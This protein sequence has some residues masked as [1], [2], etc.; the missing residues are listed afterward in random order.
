TDH[1]ES[2]TE[3]ILSTLKKIE[4]ASSAAIELMR[5]C[6]FLAPHAIPE[7]ILTEG[8]AELGSALQSVATNPVELDKGIAELRKFSLVRRSPDAKM[9]SLH[10]L[11]QATVEDSMSE[12]SRHVQASRVV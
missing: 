7:E 5:F 2:V 3:T 1:Q 6:A 10:T 12:D 9:L 11:V 4:L 8:A